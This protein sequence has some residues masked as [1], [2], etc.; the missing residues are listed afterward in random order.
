MRKRFEAQLEIGMTAIGDVKIPRNSRDELA[1][2]LLALQNIFVTPSLNEEVFA[3]LEEKI[4]AGSKNTKGREGMNLWEILVM[5]MCRLTLNADYDRTLDMLNHHTLIREIMYV[6][7]NRYS[8]DYKEFKLQT[9]K[10]NLQLLDEDTIMK[11]NELVVAAAHD[12]VLKKNEKLQIK[13][14][15]FVLETNIH[16]PTDY[17]LL[18]DS[19]RK[20]LDIMYL[21]HKEYGFVGWRKVKN[22]RS[23]LKSQ[24]R[25]VGK[26][27]SGKGANKDA[28]LKNAA[29]EY[30]E[31]AGKL[32]AK[33]NE[34]VLENYNILSQS[35]KVQELLENKLEYYMA[36][37][38]KHIDL[39]ER[40]LIKG[41]IIPTSEKIYSIFES[42]SEW[43]S[44]GKLNKKVEFGHNVLISTD[45]FGFILNSKVVEKQQDSA[46]VI[47]I[48]DK[49]LAKYKGKIASMSF[50]KGFYSKEN[51]ELLQLEIPLVIMPKKGKLNV[52]EKEEE[53]DKKFKKLRKAHSAVESNINELEHH[54]LDR[55]PDKGMKRF[56]TYTSL[57]I[58]AYNLQKIGK[59]LIQKEKEKAEKEVKKLPKAA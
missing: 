18:W 8:T 9:V 38:E 14:D 44:K 59:L 6:N 1:P 40:R 42:H 35:T 22:W 24:C 25:A 7:N 10:D 47:E 5:S 41:E 45:Q 48:T 27:N 26:A 12:L 15:S 28:S 39:V 55:C 34:T 46:L 16:F 20:C 11:I 29:T 37:L 32:Y 51:K 23:T 36:M 30:L 17:N 49:L 53:S 2:T 3:I 56:K 4:A 33:I 21:C 50:D 43:I 58:L 52:K 54:G 31:Q 57:A 13:S 19:A